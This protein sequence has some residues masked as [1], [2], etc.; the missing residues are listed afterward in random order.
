VVRAVSRGR[1]I[2]LA[3]AAVYLIWGSTY[4]AIGKTVTDIPPVFLVAARGLLAGA[5]L[6]A[7]V[8]WRG[9]A[10]VTAREVREMLPT[11]ALL[12]GGGYVMV[13]WAEQTVPSGPAALLNATTPAWVVLFEWLTH[14]RSRPA[15]MFALALGLGLGGVAL[16][17]NGRGADGE[18]PLLP[19]LALVGSSVAWA[20][21]T[22]RARAHA[23]GNA[24][25]DAAVQ[26]LTGGMLLLPVSL[27]LGEGREV[28]A[29][30]A[31]SSIIA[32]AYL[33]VFGSLIAYSAYV[34]LLHLRDDSRRS[35]A[36]PLQRV[37]H[38]AGACA[39]E[40]IAQKHAHFTPAEDRG[41]S[42][43]YFHCKLG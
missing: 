31:T 1:S 28:A 10:A 17:V 43:M 19:A 30:F 4:L 34:W 42:G 7:F 16:L 3:F 32:L 27:M 35:S 8:R 6:Y 2:W 9:A 14:R 40:A 39:G 15:L 26:L 25:R 11:A 18:L 37:L 29:G 13:A 24:V 36:H 21:G 38:R 41:V 23:Q 12:F 5:I 33:V 20:A 22:V